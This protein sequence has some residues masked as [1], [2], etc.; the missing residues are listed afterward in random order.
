M[1][2]KGTVR[3]TLAD[4]VA[5]LADADGLFGVF[6]RDL[7][8]PAGGVALDDLRCRG[9]EVGGDQREV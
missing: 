1:S 7:D 6:D 2:P 3:S 8:G 4:P 9:G 5:G